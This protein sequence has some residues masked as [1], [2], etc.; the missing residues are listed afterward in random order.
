MASYMNC[1]NG[2]PLSGDGVVLRRGAQC[3][4]GPTNSRRV[5]G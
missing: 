2:G 5:W 1:A 4:E 3:E